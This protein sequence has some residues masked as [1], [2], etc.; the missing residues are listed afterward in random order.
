[1]RIMGE[2]TEIAKNELA[3]PRFRTEGGAK[4]HL[5]LAAMESARLIF[6]SP[7][8]VHVAA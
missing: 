1:M 3:I 4:Q 8:S 6:A 5:K 2:T 7:H